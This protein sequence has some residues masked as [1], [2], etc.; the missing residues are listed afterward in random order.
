MS[1]FTTNT[2]LLKLKNA[3][4][5]KMKNKKGEMID[6]V[7]IPIAMNNLFMSDKG[8]YLEQQGFELKERK[9]DAKE[10]HLLKQSLPKAIYN[11]LTDEQKKDM[12]LL[13][14]AILWNGAPA[15]TPSVSTTSQGEQGSSYGVAQM[16]NEDDLPF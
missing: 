9:A 5:K 2:N 14:N 11:T 13:G 3:F 6:V 4:V 8:V 1:N 16:P 15:S 7:I 10:T 12:P